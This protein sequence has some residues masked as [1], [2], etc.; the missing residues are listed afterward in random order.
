MT[1]HF[2]NKIDDLRTWKMLVLNLHSNLWDYS[3]MQELVRRQA[4]WISKIKCVFTSGFCVLFFPFQTACI[5]FINS[6]HLI[7]ICVHNT[8]TCRH[9]APRLAGMC[10]FL[11]HWGNF[12]CCGHLH[13][14]CRHIF[15]LC[16]HFLSPLKSSSRLTYSCG[17]FHLICLHFVKWCGHFINA[18]WAFL[19]M[20]GHYSSST[21]DIQNLISRLA[22]FSLPA[23]TLHHSAGILSILYAFSFF[24][25]LH[26]ANACRY[27]SVCVIFLLLRA[28]WDPAGIN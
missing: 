18:W 15:N 16:R 3:K 24:I 6:V 21:V 22:I 1:N 9:F 26:F 19:M 28:F 12:Q 20:R 5:F 4:N 2:N 10:I 25:Y 8:V 11:L 17:H 27:L 7:S 23:S 13:H 14:I